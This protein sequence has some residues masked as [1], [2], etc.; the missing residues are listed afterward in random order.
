MKNKLFQIIGKSRI[1]S[2]TE[3]RE[4]FNNK[5]KRNFWDQNL[6]GLNVALYDVSQKEISINVERQNRLKFLLLG[7]KKFIEEKIIDKNLTSPEDNAKKI[8]DHINEL[9][10]NNFIKL[11]WHKIVINQYQKYAAM[12]VLMYIGIVYVHWNY[13]NDIKRIIEKH[14][15]LSKI[16]IG[17]IIAKKIFW[18]TVTISLLYKKHIFRYRLI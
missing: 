17:M 11:T 5:I 8:S 3:F 16:V 18:T 12:T 7:E 15:T 9:N 14:K 1:Y 10:K 6:S 13:L 2:H 4:K